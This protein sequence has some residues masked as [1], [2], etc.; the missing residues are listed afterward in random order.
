M[1]AGDSR[2][3]VS[4]VVHKAFIETSEEG[5]EAAAATGIV[6]GRVK[7]CSRS[8]QKNLFHG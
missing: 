4:E 6:V 2:L 1:F 3:F 7:Q 5:T 8:F